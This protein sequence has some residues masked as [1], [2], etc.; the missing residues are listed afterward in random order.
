MAMDQ[1]D[2]RALEEKCIQEHVP[3][4]SAT[5]PVHVDVRGMLSGIAKGN[6]AEG[7]RLFRK[8][9]PFPEIIARI[10]DAPCEGACKRAEMGGA[11]AIHDLE[12][13]CLQWAPQAAE[14]ITVLPRKN[15]KVAIIGGGLSGLTAAYDLSRK[16]YAVEV[17]EAS[18]RPGAGL[19]ALG[20]ALL[21]AEI[22]EKD[23]RVL[24][25]LGAKIHVNSPIL[26]KPENGGPPRL[27]SG[28]CDEFE[29]VLLAIGPAWQ[30]QVY[31]GT[32]SRGQIQID[33]VTFATTQAGVFAAGTLLHPDEPYSP[34]R[35][36]S[37]GR[38]AAIS[39]DRHLQKV[40]LTAM[41][42]NE[43]RYTTRLFTNTK[44]IPPAPRTPRQ[45]PSSVYYTTEA[46]GE[47]QR[48]IQ[49]Q[50]LECVKV[51]TYLDEYKGYPKRYVRSIYNNLSIVKG[52]RQANRMINSCSL[53]GLCAE[54]CP[55]DLN[56]A[57][58]CKEARQQMVAQGRMPAS[59]HDFALRELAFN[60][61]PAFTLLRTAPGK[62]TCEYLFFPGCQLSG[63]D[64]EHVE[65]VYGHL[66]Q[67][68]PEQVG[69]LLRCCGAPADWAGR[70]D[71]YG[72]SLAQLKA[73]IR[74][75]GNPAVVT[76]CPTCYQVLKA[77]L[78]ETRVLSLWPLLEDLG[79]PEVPES[80]YRGTAAVHDP[81]SAR[82][83]REMQDSVRR[84]ARYVGYQIEELELSRE[85]TEC[86]SFG[87]LMCFANPALGGRVAHR[88]AGESAA[89]FLTYCAM[90]R[91][92][93]AAQGKPSLHILDLFFGQDGDERKTRMG[94]G[95]S[96]RRENRTRLK[97]RMLEIYGESVM[98]QPDYGSIRLR[99]SPEVQQL[100]EKRMI[101][102]EEL[103]Q[104]IQRAEQSGDK[105]V[106]GDNGHFVAYARLGS[107]TY[108]VEYSA[109]QGDFTIHTAYSHR[110][111]I[112]EERKP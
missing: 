38:R 8:T 93:Y 21:P 112:V 22:I 45:D 3:A 98:P 42:I 6:F 103:Q 47:A 94:P 109:G 17:F 82:Y 104:V 73:D 30:S 57:A 69:I 107:V 29:V 78:P 85:K 4:C 35:S 59:A 105:L 108:W 40:S 72:E 58:I 74:S 101:L 15:L 53:C 49:C 67:K 111:E 54:V 37:E 95:H 48:C 66:S 20:A 65:R 87:G 16:G 19:Y 23:L 27:M 97:N 46:I 77:E 39:I 1:N 26:L 64:P 91:D 83:E 90:C 88:R 60:N 50:C 41:R 28:L 71:L 55:T 100:L 11:V 99:I 34:I 56:M 106:N 75:V 36:I 52:N 10:C 33:P 9:I 92:L 61:S 7:L 32:N 43:G 110:M 18:A 44:G 63:S 76:A 84:L 62:A 70:E 24:P 2:L 96:G 13:A 12:R 51:C 14:K 80:I 68:L 31:L 89:P 86:C 5:C 81:C 25:E 79:L 102:I